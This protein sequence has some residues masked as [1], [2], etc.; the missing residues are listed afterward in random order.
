MPANKISE[1]QLDAKPVDSIDYKSKN[2]DLPT[3]K[4]TDIGQDEVRPYEV[5]VTINK[6]TDGISA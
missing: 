4:L 2:I 1:I 6:T 5:H 3:R